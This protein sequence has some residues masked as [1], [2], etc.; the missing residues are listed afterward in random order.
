MLL[1]RGVASQA[2]MAV[3]LLPS[4]LPGRALAE[5]ASKGSYRPPDVSNEVCWH[6]DW[7]K[8]HCCQGDAT[9]S[10]E[11]WDEAFSFSE[12]CPN[13]E[14]WDDKRFNYE[15]CCDKEKF[16]EGG[17]EGCWSGIYTYEHCCL[18]TRPAQPWVDVLVA[19]IDTDQFYSMDE[20]YTD[21]QY[22]EDFG[23]YSTGRVLLAGEKKAERKDA[24]EFAH[25]TTYPMA[26]S[27]H[28]GRV[29]CRLLFLM[30]IELHER[31]PFRVVEMGAGSGQL[32]FDIRQCVHLNE[33]GIAPDVWRR[34]VAAFEYLIIERSPA[35]AR[36]QRDRGLHVISGDAQ[37]RSTCG[38]AL[39]A[40]AASEACS[41]GA[42]SEA[43][44][45]TAG[46][47][48]TVGSGASVVL[49]N[50]LLDAFAPLKLRL[51]VFGNPEIKDCRVWQ[52]IKFVHAIAES[53]L[54]IITR[55]LKHSESR[56]EALLV[57][58]RAYTSDVFCRITNSSV[59]QA[60]SDCAPE[61]SCLAVT[62]GLGEL[63]NHADL[64]LPSAAH[65]MRLRL[66]KDK[67]L[68]QRFRDVVSKLE[69]T[70]QD[71]V[72]LPREVY[73]QLRHQLREEPDVE[74]VFL[75]KTQTRQMPVPLNQRRC[76]QLSWWLSTH[77]ARISRLVDLYRPLGYP[78]IQLLVRPGE[79][80]FVEL[81]DCLIGKT[82]GFMLSVDYGASFEALGHSL[83]VDPNS[84]GIFIPP[85]PMDLLQDLPD[86]YGSWPTCAG[87][88]DWTTFVDFTNIAAAGEALGWRTLAYGPQSL[89]E[90]ISRRNFT[91]NGQAYSV[92]GYS[93]LAETWASRHVQNWYG[94]E[95]LPS[96]A[97]S[98][99]WQQRWTSFKALLLEK[100]A[101]PSAPKSSVIV[102]PSWHLDDE[103][104]D[105]C[106]RLDP[107]TIPLADWIRRQ[108][109]EDPRDALG[110]LSEEISDS[111]GRKYAEAYEEA[112]LSVRMVD[113]LIATEGCEN[114]SPA[115]AATLVNSR[116]LWLSLRRRLLRAWEPVWGADAID[117]VAWGVLQRLAEGP[118]LGAA[119]PYEC[120]GK[121]TYTALCEDPGG[122]S[123]SRVPTYSH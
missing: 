85:V 116:G 89:L 100:P 90:H 122:A 38:P 42:S 73:Q 10:S 91:V 103:E 79:R 65:N 40:L 88:V 117:R 33:L 80:N 52:E 108:S 96:A 22:G 69:D 76:A 53:D 24:Q 55:S 51:S 106:W 25:F 118:E 36:R 14:C 28:F 27:P 77:E 12:C 112:Q 111:L 102:F 32:G 9:T 82:G 71:V 30:W 35:L 41:E 64:Q 121:Q 23:Y 43:P 81:A 75:A 26:L 31:A 84:D 86:C 56:I 114:F 67:E 109:E 16:G 48:G 50:E 20:F 74:V 60:A 4:P 68:C 99:A 1:C 44:E 110:Q 21:A 18:A 46:D 45:C 63:M 61:S 13:A 78:A 94:C 49:S 37:S 47:E 83:S 29:V 93:V 101:V 2:L 104:V 8:E 59:G 98:A 97:D 17:N 5:V 113:W 6:G 66:R 87:R 19:D 70:L 62:L 120:L 119:A 54:Q 57:D 15:L 92:P 11:C 7:T 95:A 115:R 3:V 39:A 107:S 72:V 105:S 123:M 34:W 58:L